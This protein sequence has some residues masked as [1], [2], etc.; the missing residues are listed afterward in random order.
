M[1][2][3][4]LWF[5]VVQDPQAVSKLIKES[6]KNASAWATTFDPGGKKGVT[7]LPEHS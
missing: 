2:N 7:D 3:R 6:G 1:L 4:R 5:V